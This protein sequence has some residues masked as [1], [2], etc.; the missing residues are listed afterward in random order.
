M[1]ILKFTLTLV[2]IIFSITAI[3]LLLESSSLVDYI[4]T[5]FFAITGGYI[6]FGTHNPEYL[7][8]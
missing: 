6:L 7:I 1:T 2:G 8:K 3:M 4:Y 5:A